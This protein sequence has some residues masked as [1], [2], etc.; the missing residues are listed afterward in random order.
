LEV[1]EN[2]PIKG[3]VLWDDELEPSLLFEV[4]KKSSYL[5]DYDFLK[6]L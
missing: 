6:T 1:W 2:C 3:L 4:I 5:H